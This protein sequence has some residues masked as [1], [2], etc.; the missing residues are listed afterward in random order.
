MKFLLACSLFVS[1]FSYGQCSDIF[2]SEYIEGSSNNKAI[3]IY[4]PTGVDIDLADYRI[5][6]NANGSATPTSTYSPTGTLVAGDVFIIRN[7][8]A[9]LPEIIAEADAIAAVAGFNGDDALWIEKISTGD[10]L[11]IIGVIGEDPGSYWTVG[12]GRTQNYTLIRNI[13]VNEGQLDW[14]I[15]AT[16][17]NVFDINFVDSLGAHTSTPCFDCN[18]SASFEETACD[19][20]VS[21]SGLYTWLTSGEYMDTIPN[22]AGCDSVLTYDL[23]IVN[24]TEA[25]SEETACDS[26]LSPSGLYTW[27]ETGVY[28][29]TLTNEAGCDSVIT[30]DLTIVNATLSYIEETACDSFESPSGMFTWTTTGVYMD[31]LTNEAGCDSIIVVDLTIVTS[32]ESFIEVTTC[33]SYESPSGLYSWFESAIY[34]DT[35]SNEAGCDSIMTIDLTILGPTTYSTISEIACD[36]FV[37]PSGLYAWTESGEYID[38][39][40][41]MAG[42]DSII[43]IWLTVPVIDITVTQDENILTSNNAGVTYQWLDCDADY[44][45]IDLEVNQVFPASENG[46]Y[47]VE[48]TEDGCVDT[49]ACYEVT[50]L[51]INKN[52]FEAGIVL[53]PNPTNGDLTIELGQSAS[54]HII[55][56]NVMGQ[57]VASTSFVNAQLIA[58]NI[59]G[60]SGNYFVE[61]TTEANETARLKVT[62]F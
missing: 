23:T 13:A 33:N 15:G 42:C 7:S 55:V 34:I 26:L 37:S 53:Y 20:L 59:D 25:S 24:A 36:T 10:T 29:D 48:I 35:L 3:E 47:A 27:T 58:V 61:I 39:L 14:A 17:W 16:E 8:S 9:V 4:N 43:T 21:P 38:T 57:I 12:A 52:A 6:L 49:S 62:K 30:V 50:G 41:S 46:N 19:S 2:F 54:G 32:T 51:S 11:D 28:M 45:T 5:R 1:V 31:T 56:R 18:T 40:T 44:A 22:M 60:Q